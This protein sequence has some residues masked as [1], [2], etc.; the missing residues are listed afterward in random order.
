MNL[1]RLFRTR[2]LGA[3]VALALPAVGVG[4]SSAG[5]AQTSSDDVVTLPHTDVKD[6]AI[7]NCWLYANASW[8]EALH[9]SATGEA[10]D[11]SESYWSYWHWYLQILW[12]ADE[13]P[14]NRYA[15]M[16]EVE[17]GGF[18]WEAS[19]IMKYF[20]AMREGDFIPEEAASR[21]SS[22]QSA[23]LSAINRSLR[24]G[25]LKDRAARKDL[26]LLRR[27]LDAA[28]QLSPEVVERLD[29]A[30]GRNLERSPDESSFEAHKVLSS[31]QLLVTAVEPST[32]EKQAVSLI[33]ILPSF[34]GQPDGRFAWHEAAY[35]SD[36]AGR[37]E[38]L[39]RAQRALHDGLPPLLTF[40]VDFAAMRGSVFAD[41]P[42]SPGR[43]GGH[44]VAMSDY[45]I[46]DVPGFGTL[47]AGVDA[48]PEQLEAA[49][50]DDAR[51]VFL[52]VKNSW[53]PTGAG[54]EFTVSGHY[55]LY[56]KYLD[57]PIKNCLQPDGSTD[58]N[59]CRDET[60]FG[61]LVLPAGY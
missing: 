5:D 33:D 1:A 44:M 14:D 49:L 60:P 26:E 59:N 10:L 50:D 27:E 55:D 46:E 51:M 61:S 38:L 21:R 25:A 41:V 2:V 6:Q 16:K 31:T 57:G 45:E 3:A 43:Q 28:W 42:A 13:S 37:R 23:A 9:G 53:G 40:T 7:G 18:F 47:K 30:F 35:P 36:A 15:E 54:S 4:C 8:V 48:T 12:S 32:G 56:M 19:H 24:D 22:R 58:R 29:V 17:T 39:K 11:L 52:R 20:G 34:D